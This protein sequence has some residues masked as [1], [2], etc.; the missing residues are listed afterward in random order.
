MML[1]QLIC[2]AASAYP[3]AA[4]LQFWDMDAREP[5]INP[6][7]NDALAHYIARELTDTVDARDGEGEQIASA[8]KV[9]QES[10]DHL[11]AVAHALS[12]LGVETLAA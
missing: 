10:S 9:M 8:V 6:K 5:K 3:N 4:V 1:N 7:C 12:G 11:A 2:R